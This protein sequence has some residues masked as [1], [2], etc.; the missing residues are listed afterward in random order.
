MTRLLI[1][2]LAPLVLIAACGG[3]GER[4]RTPVAGLEIEV[5]EGAFVR[6]EQFVTPGGISVWLVNEP[7]IPILSL[8]AAWPG[9]SASDPEG[10]EG[11]ARAVAWMMNEGAGDLDALA[12]QTRMEDLNMSFGCSPGRD[13]TSC[14]ARMLTRNADDAMALVALALNDPRFDA[15]PLGRFQRE[16]RVQVERQ[17][18]NPGFL[19]RDAL[20]TQLYP[21]HPYAR[22]M[23]A[24]SIGALTPALVRNHQQ[25]IM[26]REGLLVTAVGAITPQELAPLIDDAFAGLPESSDLPDLEPVTLGDPPAAPLT[27]D[28]EQPQSL[29]MFMASGLQRSHPDFFAAYVLNHILGGG[30][31]DSRLMKELR[32][33]RGLTYGISTGLEFGGQLAAWQ[34]A[35]QTKNES[36]G[37]FVELTQA[38]LRAMARDGVTQEE[39]DRAKAFLTGAY[40]LGFDSNAKI[41]SNMMSVRQQKLGVDY[42]DR[43]N[44]AIEA[45]DL[46]EVNRVAAEWLAPGR[47]SFAVVG[48]PEGLPEPPRPRGPVPPRPD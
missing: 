15:D 48:Q 18:T 27:I 22:D 3:D 9:G 20:E 21:D 17:A 13:W 45:V 40:P 28:L 36:A 39:L 30:G 2:L 16:T 11:L 44:A 38:E 43:R 8:Q 26:T 10:F 34:G 6:I 37:T 19:A 31:L 35:G 23:S 47:F 29:V 41:A 7:S 1:A 5:H 42:F 46:N 32:E 25:R 33:K 14:S 24:Q 12:F 4:S